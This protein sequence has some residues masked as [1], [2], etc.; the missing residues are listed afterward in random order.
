MKHRGSKASIGIITH[1]ESAQRSCKSTPGYKK[2]LIQLPDQLIN[3]GSS[4]QLKFRP[5]SFIHLHML[6]QLILTHN[7]GEVRN[8]QRMFWTSQWTLLAEGSASSQLSTN[9]DCVFH[10]LI[11][12]SVE[13]SLE[14]YYI[15]C[16]VLLLL[17]ANYGLISAAKMSTCTDETFSC[18]DKLL[19]KAKQNYLIEG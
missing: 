16:T 14:I 1:S 8:S 10:G 11:F 13:S 2:D 12:R 17:L 3:L 9:V 4:P 5:T 19:K 18:I 6:I 15:L 7:T